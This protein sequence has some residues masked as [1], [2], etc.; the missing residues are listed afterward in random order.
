MRALVLNG[1]SMV[2]LVLMIATAAS[3][4]LG[5]GQGGA[6]AD[7]RT[8]AL[9]MIGLAFFKVRLVIRHFMLV[10]DAPLSL[11]LITDVWVVVAGGAVIAMYIW[12]RPPATGSADDA[13][14]APIQHNLV[15]PHAQAAEADPATA[16][17]S[18]LRG[19]RLARINRLGETRA[20]AAQ[21]CRVVSAYGARQRPA[22]HALG[23]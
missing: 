4:Y 9:V 19:V 6:S 20:H 22:D 23:A 15:A 7:P 10:R 14:N 11:R 18:P 5:T 17:I 16:V 21:A 13:R 12:A 3:W 2:W 1:F 8:A